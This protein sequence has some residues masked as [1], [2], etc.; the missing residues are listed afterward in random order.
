MLINNS[1][2]AL[3]RAPV[4]EIEEEDIHGMLD[5]NVT[6][7][8]DM[9]Q[10]VLPIFK[11][12]NHG[13]V[14]NIGSVA[15]VELYAGGSVY[16]A[17]KAAVRYFTDALRKE[18]IGTNI[19][20]MEVDPGAVALTEFS[21]TRFKGDKDAAEAVYL[22]TEPLGPEDIAE[23]IVFLCSRKENTVMAQTVVY[24]QHQASPTHIHRVVTTPE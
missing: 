2:K 12:K 7:L 14:Y 13:V 1:G 6:G 21:L 19:G 20:V 4:G 23:I 9:T 5:T 22:G 18:L 24:P 3:G 15:G 11:R 10:A 8:I 17:L 16:C